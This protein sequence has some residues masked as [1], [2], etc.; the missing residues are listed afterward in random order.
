MGSNKSF[1]NKFIYKLFAYKSYLYIF[2]IKGFLTIALSFI[3]EDN[4][5]K[6]L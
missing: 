3:V 2:I 5:P 6:T 4:S 1:K